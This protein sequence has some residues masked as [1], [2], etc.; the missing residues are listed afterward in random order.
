M[1]GS[2]NAP[3]SFSIGHTTRRQPVSLPYKQIKEDILGERYTLSLVFVGPTRAQKLNVV[4]RKKTYTPNVLAFPLDAHSGEIV[5]TPSIVKKEAPKRYMSARGYTG[6]LFI[7]ALLHL[8]GMRH[9]VTMETLE[10]KYCAR[11]ALA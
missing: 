6:F 1:G 11:Y 5:I 7:H 8:K 4:Y 3:L 10:K 2:Q 9:G